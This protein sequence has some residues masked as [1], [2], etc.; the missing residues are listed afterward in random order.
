MHTG[1]DGEQVVVGCSPF[2]LHR[3]K[4]AVGD[5]R[6]RV[7]LRHRRFALI[8]QA[9]PASFSRGRS[10]ARTQHR[11]DQIVPRTLLAEHDFEAVVEEG[12]EVICS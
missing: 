1:N 6:M 8:S 5:E 7:A 3:E 10:E 11:I 4:V 2:L 12:E 9:S